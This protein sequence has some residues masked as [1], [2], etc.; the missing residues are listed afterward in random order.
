M[1]R[2]IVAAGMS[3]VAGAAL[4]ACSPGSAVP[5]SGGTPAPGPTTATAASAPAAQPG[6]GTRARVG[7]DEATGAILLPSDRYRLTLVDEIVLMTAL[8]VDAAVCAADAGVTYYARPLAPDVEDY[9]SEATFGPWTTAQAEKFGFVPPTRDADL[10]ANGVLP[11]GAGAPDDPLAEAAAESA[12][13][14]SRDPEAERR[15]DEHCGDSELVAELKA[16]APR[17]HGSGAAPWETELQAIGVAFADRNAVP[18]ARAIW[19]EVGEC[20]RREGLRPDRHRPWYPRGYDTWTIDEEQITMA[21]ISVRCKDEVDATRRVHQLWAERE[22][23]VIDEYEPEMA[24]VA[25]AR[26]AVVE[27]AEHFVARHPEAFP[28]G[29]EPAG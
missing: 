20:Y 16:A 10:R 5:A 29:Y 8:Q 1:I 6:A 3:V 11:P 25:A 12:R 21:V 26:R 24:A 2:R 22:Q 15:L 18:E 13:R 23:R 7:F 14:L 28:P 27:R 4:A 17:R 9:L 19:D